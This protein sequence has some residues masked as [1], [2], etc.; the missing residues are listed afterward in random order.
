M[1]IAGKELYG[2]KW[3]L[4]ITEPKTGMTK[5]YESDNGDGIQIQFTQAEG[6]NTNHT[7]ECFITLTNL[8]RENRE[9]VVKENNIVELKAGY[10]ENFGHIFTGKIVLGDNLHDKKSR[11]F[12]SE[13]PNKREDTDWNTEIKCIDNSLTKKQS[14]IS[15]S[16]SEK[17]KVQTVL[18]KIGEQLGLKTKIKL[19]KGLKKETFFNGYSKI[20]NTYSIINEIANNYGMVIQIKNKALNMWVKNQGI[21]ETVYSFDATS[22]LVGSVN[23]TEEGYSFKVLLTPELYKGQYIHLKSLVVTGYYVI[24]KIGYKGNS[25]ANDWY[26]EIEVVGKV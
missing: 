11:G 4:K 2:R 13:E 8:N 22:G 16:F 7:E 10:E 14:V 20:G 26:T 17:T 1:P 12:T 19:P 9:W 18:N 21:N 25:E 3:S 24:S 6:S 23:K 15:I 5:T